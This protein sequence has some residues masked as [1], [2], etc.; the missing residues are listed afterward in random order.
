VTLAALVS[1][2]AECYALVEQNVVP[3]LSRFAD[4]NPHPVIDKEASPDFGARMNLN[5]SKEPRD[6]G[7]DARQ[8]EPMPAVK[9]AGDAVRHHRVQPGIAEHNFKP[10]LCRRIFPLNCPYV[11][12]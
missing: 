2:T 4:H 3:E 5:S 8:Y 9:P 11:F 1:G 6:L 12:S 10:A 7:Y